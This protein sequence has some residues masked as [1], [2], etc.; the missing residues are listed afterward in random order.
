MTIMTVQY[1]ADEVSKKLAQE[2]AGNLGLPYMTFASS[3]MY[4]FSGIF[5]THSTR[6]ENDGTYT[7]GIRIELME[8]GFELS[9]TDIDVR[10]GFG[11]LMQHSKTALKALQQFASVE[12]NA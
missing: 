1:L 9:W 7:P 12:S 6:F 5:V 10:K 2:V 3:E 4:G 8:R 11:F